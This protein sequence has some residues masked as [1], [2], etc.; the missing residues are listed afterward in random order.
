[1]QYII[2]LKSE[3]SKT[4]IIHPR[5]AFIRLKAYEKNQLNITDNLALIKTNT[6]KHFD[7]KE[8]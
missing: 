1:M 2:S 4:I 3:I 8:K 5:T 6:A 7:Y